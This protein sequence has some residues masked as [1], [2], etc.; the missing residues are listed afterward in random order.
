MAT[1]NISLPDEMRRFVDQ[2]VSA[3]GYATA[4]EYIRALVRKAQ[5]E[6]GRDWL[7]AELH[8][9][10]DSLDAGKGVVA[11]DKFWQRQ[12]ARLLDALTTRRKQKRRA[13]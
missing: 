3:G 11:D 12:R 1:L 10:I 9:G 13:L 6:A 8:K 5:K 4:S 7:A 2:Q